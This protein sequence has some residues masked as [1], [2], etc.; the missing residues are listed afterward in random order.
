VTSTRP[1]TDDLNGTGKDSISFLNPETLDDMNLEDIH[2]IFPGNSENL[3]SYSDLTSQLN[4]IIFRLKNILAL[5]NSS[6]KRHQKEPP[7]IE[8]LSEDDSSVE[9]VD[10][11][12]IIQKDIIEEDK[13]SSGDISEISKNQ[14]NSSVEVQK[15]VDSSGP[16]ITNFNATASMN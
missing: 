7:V 4:D 3:L 15:T 1:G 13:E 8:I 6:K 11:S 10:N 9:Y 14:F 16:K 12:V 2:K 5:N